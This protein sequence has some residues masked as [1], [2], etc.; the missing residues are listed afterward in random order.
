MLRRPGRTFLGIL[1]EGLACA[2]PSVGTEQVLPSWT[3]LTGHG[4]SRFAMRPRRVD[5]APGVI[6]GRTGIY[7]L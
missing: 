1:R 7:R 6:V 2:L 5:D 4:S 3:R